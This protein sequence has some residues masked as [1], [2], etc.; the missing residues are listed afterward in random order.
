MDSS[1]SKL[2]EQKATTAAKLSLFPDKGVMKMPT[3]HRNQS[4]ASYNSGEA[5]HESA[6]LRS[7]E[8]TRAVRFKDS[9]DLKF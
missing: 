5:V 7:G 1:F 8:N 2:S 4:I 6:A 3:I 9:A